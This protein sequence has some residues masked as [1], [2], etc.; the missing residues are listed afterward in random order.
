M[1]EY[2]TDPESISLVTIHSFIRTK[3]KQVPVKMNILHRRRRKTW[4]IMDRFYGIN[5]HDIKYTMITNIDVEHISTTS[6]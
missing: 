6:V 3:K 4:S 2:P 5:G 1:T